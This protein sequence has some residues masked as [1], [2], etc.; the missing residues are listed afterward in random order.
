MVAEVLISASVDW[1][2]VTKINLSFES[3]PPL[4]LFHSLIQPGFNVMKHLWRKFR[5]SRF[6]FK[7]KKQE[8]AIFKAINSFSVQFC[9]KIALLFSHLSVVS[10][11]GTNFIQFLNFWEIQISSKKSFITSTTG[12]GPMIGTFT[13]SRRQPP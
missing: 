3:I 12:E 10:D 8:Q 1:I 11:I 6:P 2:E 5:K 9:L 4:S 7:P 13:S